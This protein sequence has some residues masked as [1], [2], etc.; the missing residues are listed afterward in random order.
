MEDE[1]R[2]QYELKLQTSIE[3]LRKAYEQQMAENKARFSAMYDKKI[4]ELESKLM[5]ERIGCCVY[6][7]ICT[8]WNIN[9]HCIICRC[10]HCLL[11]SSL[12]HNGDSDR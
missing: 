12:E 1:T 8:N 10:H 3:E 7:I 2:E 9:Y 6:S 5:V 4:E 11:L